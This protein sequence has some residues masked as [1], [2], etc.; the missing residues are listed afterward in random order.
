VDVNVTRADIVVVGGGSAGCTA[1]IHAQQNLPRGRVVLLEKAHIKRS[2][3]I[4]IG[5]DG[6]N[7][8][9]IPGFATPEQ[10]VRVPLLVL[11]MLVLTL[12]A[13]NGCKKSASEGPGEQTLHIA[14]GTQDLTISCASGGLLVRELGLLDRYL[15]KTGKYAHVHYEVEWRSYTSGPPIST[16]LV[17]SKVDMGLMGDFPS[18]ANADAFRKLGKR[19]LYTAIISG[20]VEGGGN[21]VLVPADSKVETLADLKGKQISVPFG[22][23]AHGT[24]LRALR[25]LGWDPEKDV[26]LI[27]QTPEVGGTA[28]RGHKIDAHADFVPYTELFPFRKYA[29]KIYD[30]STAHVPTSVGVVVRDDFAERYPEIV[31]AFLQATLEG[32]RLFTEEPEKYS[33]FVQ[34]VAGVDAEV[35]YIFQGPLGIQTRDYSLK[36]EFRQGLKTAVATFKDLKKDVDVDIDA[37]VDD[38]FIRQAAKESGLDYDARLARYSPVPITAPDAATGQPITDF[39]LAAQLW[40]KDEPKVR[41]YGSIASAL[42][43]LSELAATGKS[44]RAIYVHDRNSGSKL[45][46]DSAYY[47]RQGGE[48]SAFLLKKDAESWARAHGGS[49]AL[50][51]EELRP[52]SLQAVVR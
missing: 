17:A 7:N 10:Y 41:A 13:I 40:V 32:D 37:F 6:L 28:L 19:S 3:A 50:R 43:A 20:S 1:A 27:S 12:T 11:V 8:A 31:V 44:T 39:K 51:W 45:F 4:A 15:P 49:A 30:G 26:N 5:M 9:I 52:A 46:A 48:I 18:V 21:A 36:P 33:E 35:V 38:R 22:S 29:R 47:T 42:T 34:K 16:D 14:I 25:D 2:G 24:L 23:S